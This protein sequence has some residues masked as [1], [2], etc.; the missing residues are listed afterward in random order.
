VGN[1]F[2]SWNCL[3][4]RVQV[5]PEAQMKTSLGLLMTYV[6]VISEEDEREPTLKDKVLCTQD[7]VNDQ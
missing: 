1:S 3:I 2:L 7:S 4:A 5:G 6:G